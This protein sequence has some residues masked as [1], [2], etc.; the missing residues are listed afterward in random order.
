MSGSER[1][2]AAHRSTLSLTLPATRSSQVPTLRHQMPNTKISVQCTPEMRFCAFDSARMV[3][4]FGS[5]LISA[6][7]MCGCDVSGFTCGVS[8]ST[9]D[10]C[11]SVEKANEL[12]ILLMDRALRVDCM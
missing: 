3:L 5:A 7:R 4:C 8:Q 6:D 10:F 11:Q 1:A 12:Q 2:F 9:R